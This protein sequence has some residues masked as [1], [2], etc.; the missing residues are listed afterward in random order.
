M[1][2]SPLGLEQRLGF[3]FCSCQ[4]LALT[5]LDI[6]HHQAVLTVT[7][8]KQSRTLGCCFWRGTALASCECC[9][10][11]SCC[12]V[13]PLGTLAYVVVLHLQRMRKSP[14]WLEQRLG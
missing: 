5:F 9:A 13:V 4:M 11:P 10:R 3:C 12:K 7:A 14:L 6:L 1:G 2:R 8:K